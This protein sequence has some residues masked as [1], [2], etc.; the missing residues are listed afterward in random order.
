[1]A[2]RNETGKTGEA[3][4]CSYLKIC[5]YTIRH[6]NWRYRHYELDIVALGEK[7]L[8]V[9]EVKTRSANHLLLP[10]A[11]IDSGKI[12]R[13]AIAADAYVHQYKI[14]LPVRFD[15]ICLIKNGPSCTVEKHIEDAFYAPVQASPAIIK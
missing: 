9:V 7:E 1:M 4:A 6:T 13:I 8:V 12:Q 5:G 15:V 14:D 3:A 2:A 10:E 11:S